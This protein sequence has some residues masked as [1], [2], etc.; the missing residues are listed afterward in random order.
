M[1]SIKTFIDDREIVIYYP[2]DE[3]GKWFVQW[4]GILLGYV[5]CERIEISSAT[6]AWASSID[7][8]DVYLN[9]ITNFIEHSNL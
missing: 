8:L 9:E 4:D 3:A 5:Y 6:P 1:E 7:L 2:D